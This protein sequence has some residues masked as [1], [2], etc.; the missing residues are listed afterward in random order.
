MAMAMQQ[1]AAAMR[2]PFRPAIQAMFD[3]RGSPQRL[4]AVRLSPRILAIERGSNAYV[5][6]MSAGTEPSK[7]SHPRAAHSIFSQASSAYSATGARPSRATSY[8]TSGRRARR[9]LEPLN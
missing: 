6:G 4:D 5:F 1:R 2:E 7:D 3:M 8:H 9:P